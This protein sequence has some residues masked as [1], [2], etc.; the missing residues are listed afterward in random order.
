MTSHREAEPIKI[1]TIFAQIDRR[2]IVR[3]LNVFGNVMTRY[4]HPPLF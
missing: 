1:T 3:F 4:A 2:L